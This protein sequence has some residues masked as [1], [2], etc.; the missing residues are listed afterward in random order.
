M[1]NVNKK[2]VPINGTD[3]NHYLCSSNF[4]ANELYIYR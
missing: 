3:K 4:E 1:K 2:V